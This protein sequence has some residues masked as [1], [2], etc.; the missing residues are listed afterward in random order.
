MLDA[1]LPAIAALEAAE[2]GVSTNE[3]LA[4]AVEAA[5]QGVKSTLNVQALAGRAN[6]VNAELMKGV[7]DPGAVAVAV[8]FEAAAK[9]L[10]EA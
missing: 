10:L 9:S 3:R 7:P 4:K 6:Y 5:Q 1:L 8:A 2:D